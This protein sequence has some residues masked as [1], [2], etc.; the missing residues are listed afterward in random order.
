MYQV[1]RNLA[2]NS[3]KFTPPGGTVT[4]D[5]KMVTKTWRGLT[6]SSSDSN[7]SGPKK[8]ATETIE[9]RRTHPLAVVESDDVFFSYTDR[10]IRV[11]F[12]DTGVG[13][14]EV[15]VLVLLGLPVL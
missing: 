14:S 15:L 10:F 9:T 5:V 13:I 8:Q 3:L 1:I 4:V 7:L 6:P 11:E 12:V 2:S